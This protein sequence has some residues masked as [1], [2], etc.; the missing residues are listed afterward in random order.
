M[1][2]G[3]IGGRACR[4]VSTDQTDFYRP[5]PAVLG[6]LGQLR[7]AGWRIAVVTNGSPVQH[8]KVERAGLAALVDAICVSSE[9]GRAKP[10]P[11]IFLEAGRCAPEIG[12]PDTVMVGDDP[13]ADI[14]GAHALGFATIWLD[15]GRAW[16]D[17][18]FRPD[19]TVGSV[20]AAVDLIMAPD[21]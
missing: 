16:P 9:I 15:R 21:G 3:R 10:H 18:G 5:E 2:S 20:G 6:P 11:A 14:A 19:H 7:A 17:L 1:G 4:G 12:P 13:E 8:R